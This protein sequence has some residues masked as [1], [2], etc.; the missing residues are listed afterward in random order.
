M[1][2]TKKKVKTVE[3]VLDDVKKNGSVVVNPC[4]VCVCCGK[5]CLDFKIFW[6]ELPTCSMKCHFD[7]LN[8]ERLQEVKQIVR[9]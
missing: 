7:R 4:P 2:S 8:K 6:K 1:V 3:Q 9:R 5:P